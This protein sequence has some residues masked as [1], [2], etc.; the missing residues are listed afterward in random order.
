MVQKCNCHKRG[1]FTI[2]VL[3]KGR[4]VEEGTHDELINLKGEYYQ[5]YTGNFSIK[6]A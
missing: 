6:S 2:I 1:G 3:K 5:L 4:I